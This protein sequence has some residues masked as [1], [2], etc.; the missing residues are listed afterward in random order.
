L[1]GKS[2]A[3]VANSC[4]NIYNFRVNLI[5]KLYQH[6][7]TIY[8][9]APLDEYISYK[10]NFP[11]LRH[12][13]LKSLSRKNL[14]PIKELGIIAELHKIFK[15]VG[16]D[17]IINYTHKPNIYGAIAARLAGIPSIGVVTG[18]GYAFIHK[19]WLNY[20]SRKLY[21]LTNK[22]HRLLI[23]ENEDDRDLFVELGLINKK[24]TGT[25]KGCGVDINKYSPQ[26]DTNKSS[27][28]MIFSFLGRL[29][30]DKGI[31]EFVEA[32]KLI[33]A[34]HDNVELWITGEL[35]SGNPSMIKKQVL[36]DWMDNDKIKY[37]GFVDNVKPIMSKSDCI[38]LPSYREGMP[39]VVLEAM[40][41]AKAVIVSN[42]AGCRQTVEDG[43]NGFIAEVR[44]VNSL[45]ETM[46]KFM[47]LNENQRLGM[48]KEG[49][50]KVL[51]EFNSEKISQELYEIISQ[52][53]FCS[54]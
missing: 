9:I 20:I 13:A 33:L 27:D 48:G 37:F 24:K 40:S 44:S 14:N 30:Y 50:R 4:W 25:V 51:E 2:I 23:F 12:V 41:M 28:K 8:V 19:G 36:L 29:L 53:Y 1:E 32:G 22:F 45:A 35:D 17:I 34:K 16:P 6:K 54:K 5:E 31:C 15:E 3:I 38:V 43:I 26:I 18:L 11:D 21:W 7:N 52:V 49:R 47:Q 42:T 39:R 10:E 46:E